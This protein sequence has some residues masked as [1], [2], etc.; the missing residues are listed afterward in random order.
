MLRR[1]P[2]ER[3]SLVSVVVVVEAQQVRDLAEGDGV[4]AG[5]L[6]DGGV[7]LAPVLSQGGL[8]GGLQLIVVVPVK[9]KKKL[10]QICWLNG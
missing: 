4:G 1:H 9:K 2:V 3:L 10:Y 6:D 5:Q 8:L 7:A